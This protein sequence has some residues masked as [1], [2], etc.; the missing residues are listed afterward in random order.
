MGMRAL[1]LLL[2]AIVA[3][4]CL[5]HDHARIQTVCGAPIPPPKTRTRPDLCG[6]WTAVWS[7]A[8]WP[9]IFLPGGGYVA[10]RPGLLYHG[11]WSLKGDV[12][13]IRER[14]VAA[15]HLGDY[16]TYTFTLAPGQLR[17]ADAGLRLV[18]AR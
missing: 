13:T 16:T 7:G 6:A 1:P 10:E 4:P 3:T 17:T 5:P 18:P 2:A 15:D 9:T 12:L 8:E 14:H 11:S